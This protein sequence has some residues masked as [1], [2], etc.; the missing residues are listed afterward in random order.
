MNASHWAVGF[1]L[2][3]GSIRAVELWRSAPRVDVVNVVVLSA[4]AEGRAETLDRLLQSLGSAPY[5]E[6]ARTLVLAAQKLDFDEPRAAR[7]ELEREATAALVVAHRALR[8]F[9]WLDSFALVAIV[10]AGLAAAL[11][12]QATLVV[13]LELLAATLLW[14]ANVRAA[15]SI[16]LRMVTGAEALV[17]GLAK[18]MAL[19]REASS[20]KAGFH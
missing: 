17:D 14:L 8:R 2:L 20:R 3:V 19:A 6:V 15:R 5:F 11:E 10:L 16:G 7:K 12:R 4:L 18:S 13:A 9:A 1:A